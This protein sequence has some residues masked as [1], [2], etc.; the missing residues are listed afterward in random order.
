M[1]IFFGERLNSFIIID[2]IECSYI[3]T[4]LDRGFRFRPACCRHQ[5]LHLNMAESRWLFTILQSSFSDHMTSMVFLDISS[6]HLVAAF[7][8]D[9][10]FPSTSHVYYSI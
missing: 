10:V 7:S 1:E 2:G 3:Q 6:F 5:V 9:I 4:T 8:P